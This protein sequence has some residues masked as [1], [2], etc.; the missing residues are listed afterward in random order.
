MDALSVSAGAAGFISLGITVCQ[1]L[2]DYYRSW[3]D[4]EDQVAQM[5]ASIEALTETFRLL[6]S[7]IQSQVFNHATVQ[8]VEESIRSAERGLQSLQKKLQKIQLA[9]SQP[10]WKARGMAQLRRSL[11]PFKESTL[12]KL[13]E[14][15]IELRQELSLALEVL[16]IECSAASLQ[17]LDVVVHGLNKVSIDVDMLQ[18]QSTSMSK[19]VQS[20]DISSQ[21]M[22]K[23]VGDL[24]ATQSDEYRRKVFDWLS[25]LTG[26][27]Q[28][29]HLDTFNTPGR[30]DAAAQSLLETAKFRHWQCSSG[31]T[32]WCPGIRESNLNIN[33]VTPA[34]L[35]HSSTLTSTEGTGKTIFAWDHRST[36]VPSVMLIHFTDPI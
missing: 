22:L 1:G 35:R 36:P 28:R 19:N 25:P 17:K 34:S 16:Q 14:L 29:K 31:E 23:S 2:L 18:E 3:K 20:L 9:P 33:L 32:L 5:Y 10:G 4:A 26:D 27:F 21:S 11:F 24:V 6:E 12:A 13:K 8:K 15:G 30:Q 7:A